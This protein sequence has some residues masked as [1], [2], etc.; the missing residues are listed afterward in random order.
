MKNR[1]RF[2]SSQSKSEPKI[3]VLRDALEDAGA[4]AL[5]LDRFDEEVSRRRFLFGTSRAALMVAG[6]GAGAEVALHGLLGRGLI[7]AAWGEDKPAADKAVAEKPVDVAAQA[8]PADKPDIA[9]LETHPF[10][11]EFA[12]H[13]LD[14]DV[15]PNERHFVRNHGSPSERAQKK[16][17][18]G[19]RLRVDGEVHKQLD[20]TMDD[21]RRFPKVEMNVVVECAGNGRGLFDPPVRGNAWNRG[22]VGCARWTGAR[23]SDVLNA[24][25]VKDSAKYTAHY[26]EDIPIAGEP[27]S[28]GVPIAKALDPNTL[29]AYQMNGKDIPALNGYPVRL[30]V[31]GWIG[32]SMQ[33]WLNRIW[34]R[35]VVHDSKGMG[36]YRMPVF[37]AAPGSKVDDKDTDIVMAWHIKS[38]ITRPQEGA[39][40][41]LSDVVQVRG[42]AWAGEDRVDSVL[43]STNYGMD[44]LRTNLNAPANRYAWSTWNIDLQFPS[45]GYYEIWVRAF[46]SQNRTQ[47][48][49][50]PWNPKGFLS[51]VV[52]RVPVNITA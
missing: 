25:G 35:D 13:L 41:K 42:H 16:D 20:L 40:F 14:D 34:I 26:G 21:L 43:V 8:V 18:Q 49:K 1:R 12:A 22:A 32:S 3:S 7:P 36:A 15:T 48:F 2:P 6:L 38:M 11:G 33:K 39:T 45:R 50:Q 46:D 30:L 52:H 44:W 19:W 29:V 9:I 51:N 10:N 47:P 24:A 27:F 17:M 5:T 4:D 28:R 31:P 37:P 23:L